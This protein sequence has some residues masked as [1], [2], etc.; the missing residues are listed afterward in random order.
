MRDTTVMVAGGAGFIGSQ[1]VRELLKERA[2]VVVLDNFQTGT[3][4]NLAEV[5][6]SIEVVNGDLL[7]EWCLM[8]AFRTHRPQRVFN[9]V[10]ETFVPT[11]Y[12]A[13]KR[14]VR[15]NVEGHINVLLAARHF[16]V[17]RVVYASSAEV[18][19]NPPPRAVDE[20][21]PLGAANTYAVTK[22]AADRL[23]FSMQAEHGI[24]V[25]AARL[26]NSYGPRE[27][28]PYI[29]PEI[30]RQL[31]AGGPLKLG[32]LEARRDYT[33]VADTAS[34]LV[35]IMT[36]SIP[37][38]QA[39]NVGS[40]SVLSV[41]ELANTIGAI[42]E[43]PVEFESVASRLRRHDIQH[44]QADN[45]LL[46]EKTG[47]VPKLSIEAGLKETVTWFR[48]NGNRW[49]WQDRVTLASGR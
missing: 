10:G 7:D 12:D 33:Y 47:W 1:L 22:L 39:V 38:G 27:T 13:P 2:R 8:E 29:V 20:K 11:V 3:W 28:E 14:F 44:L 30:V 45:T 31:H 19:G 23:C 4:S 17:E 6:D 49:P 21:Q 40:N 46:R 9:L 16:E 26:F 24:P 34:A 25:V 41:A 36:S 18:Y 37:N 15:V 5:R 35:A 48:E 43:R 42:M 32:N